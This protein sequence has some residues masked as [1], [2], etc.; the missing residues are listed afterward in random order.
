MLTVIEWNLT[1]VQSEHKRR[2]NMVVNN[3]D[4]FC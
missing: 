1:I 3:G 2:L 4:N